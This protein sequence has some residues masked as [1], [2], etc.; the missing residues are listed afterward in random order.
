MTYLD[1]TDTELDEGAQHL[2]TSDLVCSTADGTFDQQTVVMRL[3]KI[4]Y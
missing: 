4:K 2:A 3:L 1:T